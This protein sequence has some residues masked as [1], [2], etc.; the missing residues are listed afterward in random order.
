MTGRKLFKRILWGY[1]AISL[2]FTI[3]LGV[4]LYAGAFVNA[5]LDFVAKKQISLEQISKKIDIRLNVLKDASVR[6]SEDAALA[7]YLAD[8][9]LQNANTLQNA[10]ATVTKDF[11]NQ[12]LD[13]Y[14]SS[15]SSQR[16][17]VIGA[18]E[19]I[20]MTEF[21]HLYSF[22]MGITTSIRQHFANKD[23]EEKMFISYASSMSSEDAGTIVMIDKKILNGLD[24]Y[25]IC[26]LD[27][28]MIFEDAIKAEGS[29]AILNG[30]N[31][32]CNVGKNTIKSSNII[33]NVIKKYT[34]SSRIRTEF[35]E[36]NLYTV[37][38][39]GTHNWDYIFACSS[40]PLST[41]A[42]QIFFSTFAIC[43]AVFIALWLL[44]L[45]LARW[46]YSP[47]NK[48]IGFL[49]GTNDNISDE[50]LFV[51]Q[52]FTHMSS[53]I[54]SLKEKLDATAYPLRTK[55]LKDLMFGLLSEE[56]IITRMDELCGN[57]VEGPY[58]V[59]LLKFENYDLLLDAFSHESIDK[60]KYQIKEFIDDQLKEQIIHGA[61][62]IDCST[63]SAISYGSD[64]R[65]L[66][67]LL[68][69]MAMMVE[70]SFEVGIIG[71]IGADCEKLSE[72]STSYASSCTIMENRF[73]VG[74]RN[75]IVAEEDVNAANTYGFYYPLDVERE[76]IAEVIRAHSDET[77]RIIENILVENFEKRSLAKDRVNAFIFAITASVNRVAEALNKTTDEI[78]GEG[79][80]VFLDLKMCNDAQELRAKI[81]E[82]FDKVIEY[83]NMENKLEQDNLADSMLDYI[84]TH[85]N[86][87]ISLLDIG[88]H[89]DLSQCY[90]STLFKEAT[91]E[92][93]KDYLSR[94]RIKMAKQILQNEPWV[95]NSELASRI[96]CNTVATLFRLFNKYEGTSPGQY[97]KTIKEQQ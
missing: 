2:V 39:S 20:N 45:L 8:N 40:E 73:T 89:F 42:T 27:A 5:R 81:H 24:A 7:N 67:E 68:A 75:A 43:C 21:L 84:H 91:G 15:F 44:L 23:S 95:K 19:Q 4:C 51:R 65:K 63:I 54:S 29:F 85:Y 69:D 6:I 87:D 17:N 50:G 3:I 92:N 60:I 1:I 36:K 93:F 71:A 96:G 58:R 28:G 74:S 46:V 41:K 25:I 32:I 70:G 72:I 76:L 66:R 37:T 94:Y 62:D 97:V 52:K 56:E 13:M 59:V 55:L 26:T 10:I 38:K 64:T 79:S 53:D 33:N 57:E 82:L 90:T 34:P 9:N 88:G 47:I 61:I 12:G 49:A 77:H 35:I 11:S 14:V 80:I 48:T 86:E 30:Q 83:I 31:L 18:N 22:G 78:F 16:D